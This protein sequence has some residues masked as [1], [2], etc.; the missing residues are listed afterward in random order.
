LPTKR[1]KALGNVTNVCVPTSAVVQ[2]MALPV[3]EPKKI[4]RK[5]KKVSN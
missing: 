3:K 4:V 1:R 5:E 2:Q